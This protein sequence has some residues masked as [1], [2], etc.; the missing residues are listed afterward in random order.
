M[1]QCR[2]FALSIMAIPHFFLKKAHQFRSR[3]ISHNRFGARHKETKFFLAEKENCFVGNGEFLLSTL[4]NI[5]MRNKMTKKKKVSFENS[6][7]KML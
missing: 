2:A 4:T 3:F 7:P 5:Y 1:L 6:S